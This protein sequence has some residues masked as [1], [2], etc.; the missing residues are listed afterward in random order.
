[1]HALHLIDESGSLEKS[2][3]SEGQ[4]M[5]TSNKK[6]I[7]VTSLPLLICLS[8]EILASNSSTMGSVTSNQMPFL[9]HSTN[10]LQALT[11]Q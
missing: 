8:Q 3:I 5:T 7:S 11:E 4:I 9:S 2:N 10:R 6:C 1:M